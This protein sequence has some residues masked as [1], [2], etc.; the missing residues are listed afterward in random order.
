M[1]T[2]TILYQRTLTIDTTDDPLLSRTALKE[3]ANDAWG[4]E[5]ALWTIWLDEDVAYP[6]EPPAPEILDRTVLIALNALMDR[7]PAMNAWVARDYAT[8]VLYAVAGRC[9]D[10]GQQLGGHDG[11]VCATDRIG[12]GLF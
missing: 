12:A 11:P 1:T 9:T 8:T 7:Y 6:F 5:G 10:C 2:H 4:D 3:Y